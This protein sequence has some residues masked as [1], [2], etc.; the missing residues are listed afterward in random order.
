MA[1]AEPIVVV[2]ELEAGITRIEL[3]RPEVRNALNAEMV[4]ELNRVLD[5]V[6]DDRRCRVVILTGRG[7][8]FCS[9]FD[10][11]GYGTVD[12]IAEP[13]PGGGN[14]AAWSRA[15]QIHIGSVIP[16]LRALRQPVIAAVNG[17]AVGG[18]LALAVASDIRIAAASARFGIGFVRI[19]LSGCDVSVS[20]TLPKLVGIGHAHELMLTGRVIDAD[21]A[22]QIGLVTHVVPGDALLEEAVAIAREVADNAPLGIEATKRAMWAA[23][24]MPSQAAAMDLENLTQE[25]LM[26]TD[27]YLEARA[28][29]HEQRPPR[30]RGA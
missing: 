14:R 5:A 27:D 21:Q 10:L 13:E 26:Q 30:W 15:M 1:S 16:H 7:A 2:E 6:G 11:G 9:G 18:G 23:L 4:D 29:R 19:G 8:G 12:G 28:A 24:E 25:Y 22:R 17:A 20:W 3:N